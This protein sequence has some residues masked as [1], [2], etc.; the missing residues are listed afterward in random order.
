MPKNIDNISDP[1]VCGGVNSLLLLVGM[2]TGSASMGNNT[3]TF[4][5]IKN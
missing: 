3:E 2:S 5:K 1:E 4:L